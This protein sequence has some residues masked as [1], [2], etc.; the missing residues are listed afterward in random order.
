MK[1][2]SQVPI[3]NILDISET[4]SESAWSTDVTASDTERL[5][6]I[7]NDD[8]GSVAQSDD[9][10]SVARSDDTRSETDENVPPG[11]RRLSSSSNSFSNNPMV[12]NYAANSS[13]LQEYRQEVKNE[14]VNGKIYH[15]EQVRTQVDSNANNVMFKT[16]MDTQQIAH[17]SVTYSEHKTEIKTTYNSR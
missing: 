9:T 15:S 12:P 11:L 17:N 5:I 7:D 3:G 1:I 13:S 2:T 16:T 6:E 14:G 8:A 4:Q 10:N